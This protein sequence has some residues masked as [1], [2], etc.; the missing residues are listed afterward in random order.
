MQLDEAIRSRRTVRQFRPD[1]VDPALVAELI[2]LATW[3]PNHRMAEPWHFYVAM[4]AAKEPLCAIHRELVLEEAPLQ[5]ERAEA[6]YRKLLAIPV[7]LVVTVQGDENPKRDLENY[8]A[9]CCA[10]QNLSLA[11]HARGLGTVW[12]TGNVIRDRRTRQWLGLGATERIVGLV[13]L[14]YPAVCPLPPARTPAQAKAT[15]LR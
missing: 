15:F 9:V 3:A 8:A 12:R 7:F 14:G 10:I 6:R 5:A 2:E 4:G 11:A 13:Q 1:P